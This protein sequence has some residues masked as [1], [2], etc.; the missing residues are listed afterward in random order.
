VEFG[1]YKAHID[2]VSAG[3]N[4]GIDAVRFINIGQQSFEYV[5]HTLCICHRNLVVRIVTALW[6]VVDIL[7]FARQYISELCATCLSAFCTLE[8][9]ISQQTYHI[10]ILMTVD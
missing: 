1:K 5:P 10:A 9:L 4:V 2:I 6:R 3:G 7:R 8:L